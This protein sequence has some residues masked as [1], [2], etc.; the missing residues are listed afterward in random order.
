VIATTQGVLAATVQMLTE[1]EANLIKLN[2][3]ELIQSIVLGST[4]RK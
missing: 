1:T 3:L 2:A 4:E